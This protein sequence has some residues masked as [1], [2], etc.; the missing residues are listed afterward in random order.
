MLIPSFSSKESIHLHAPIEK[1]L[2]N[3]PVSI[4]THVLHAQKTAASANHAPHPRHVGIQPPC[5]LRATCKPPGCPFALEP[6]RPA[7]RAPL[8][9]LR[10]SGDLESTNHQFGIR[11][12]PS[13]LFTECI[14]I[15]SYV[16]TNSLKNTNQLTLKFY[17]LH[18]NFF[19]PELVLIFALV[20]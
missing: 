6:P 18:G 14:V 12:A 13:R 20:R 17:F 1:Q 10:A 8:R 4:S 11:R 9:C 5:A 19:N 15:C 2:L 7:P 3:S 16:C